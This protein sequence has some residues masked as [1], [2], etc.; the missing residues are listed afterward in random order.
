M[1]F[2]ASEYDFRAS[3]FHKHC[4]NI[5]NTLVLIRTEFGKTL[6][7]FTC[8]PWKSQNFV[9]WVGDPDGRAFLFSLDMKEKFVPL[10]CDKLICRNSGW[11]PVFGTGFDIKILDG[12][13]NNA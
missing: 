8:T 7:G 10:D 6:G 9:D 1:I 11:G 4:D 12:C 5:K 2:R 3:E 13:N